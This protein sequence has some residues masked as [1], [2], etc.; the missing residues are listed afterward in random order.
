MQQIELTPRIPS[1]AW[2]RPRGRMVDPNR[3][4]DPAAYA[5][6]WLSTPFYLDEHDA[7]DEAA[8]DLR[9]EWP[10]SIAHGSYCWSHFEALMIHATGGFND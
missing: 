2:E 1:R 7:L 4:T 8:G 6:G 10:Y 3:V 5:V 9:N